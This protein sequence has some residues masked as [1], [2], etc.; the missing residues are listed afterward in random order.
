MLDVY[1]QLQFTQLPSVANP[2]HNRRFNIN[3]CH[4]I[5]AEDSWE[6][7]TNNAKIT[8]PKALRYAGKYGV[9]DNL[10]GVNVNIGGFD[11]DP[12]FLKGDKVD[13]ITGYKYR[14]GNGNERLQSNKIFT[15]YISNV[16]SGTPIELE[17]EDNMWLLKQIPAPT[18]CFPST[19][20][21]EDLLRDVIDSKVCPPQYKDAVSKLTVN[22]ITK[23]TVGQFLTQGET[24]MQIL[25]RFRKDYGLE[26]YFKGN[27]LRIGLE[28]YL[29]NEA[30]N[31][32][33]TFQK[34][35]IEDELEYQRKDDLVLSALATNTIVEN[36]GNQTKDGQNKTK[37]TQLQV[38][39][40][41]K[42]NV[43]TF[44]EIKSGDSVSENTEGQRNKYFFPGAQNIS[45]LGKLA[46]KKLRLLY[47]DGLTG[48]FTTFGLPYV[49]QGDSVE[50][51]DNILPERNGKY[52][53]K[54]VDYEGGVGGLRQTISLHMKLL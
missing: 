19:T 13:I 43:A 45:E 26:A 48:S 6:D 39:V 29:A 32:K 31:H 36:T 51:V 20:T 5:E 50:L 23:T 10:K 49:K 33:F 30:A 38:L 22:A 53:V 27:E 18:K 4:K 17:M 1:S 42:N 8:L 41:L 16:G 47:Y 37:K 52:R 40:T 2:K 34:N 24:V 7:F 14:D 15:G 54:K 12:L 28:V 9:H 21:V 35:I 3:F 25:A 46:E 44:K 11:S